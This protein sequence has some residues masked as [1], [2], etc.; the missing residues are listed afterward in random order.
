[1]Q[2]QLRLVRYASLFALL[3]ALPA[4]ARA[5]ETTDTAKLAAPLRAVR[6]A[7]AKALTSMDGNGAASAFADSVYVEFQGQTYAG[8]EAAT[9]WLNEALQ[10]VSALRFSEPTFTISDAEVTERATYTVST[11]GGDAQGT[12]QTTWKRQKDGSW[13]MARLVVT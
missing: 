9:A 1:M 10:G 3:L 7:Y 2:N 11:P 12:T 13:K 4:G 6:A 8:K 5:Q